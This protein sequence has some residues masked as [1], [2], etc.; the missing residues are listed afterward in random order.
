MGKSV[1]LPA[2]RGSLPHFCFLSDNE[3][4]Q[5]RGWV[6]NLLV[7]LLMGLARAVTLVAESHRTHDRILLTR[8]WLPQ[9]GKP[10]PHIY[11]PQEQGDPLKFQG[12]GSPF[13]RLLR[14]SGLQWKYSLRADT[15]VNTFSNSS[16]LWRHVFVAAE[17][18]LLVLILYCS[19]LLHCIVQ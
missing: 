2:C 11:I 8:L 13:R 12:T 18:C 5:T 6:C 3:G 1:L 15:I 16:L 9:P 19:I 14:L 7:Q 17:T 10:F 4:F